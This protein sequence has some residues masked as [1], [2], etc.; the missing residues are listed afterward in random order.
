VGVREQAQREGDEVNPLVG[1]R[2][3]CLR[4]ATAEIT[5]AGEPI[6]PDTK[7]V[8]DVAKVYEKHVRRGIRIA[9]LGGGCGCHGKT[10]DSADAQRKR[11]MLLHENVRALLGEHMEQMTLAQLVTDYDLVFPQSAADRIDAKLKRYGLKRN[12][13][14][15]DV[16]KWIQ[17]G[18]LP[19]AKGKAY[20]P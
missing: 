14:G 6:T 7:T 2:L 16:G 18:L 1:I 3:E 19:G 13:S 17:T 5:Y 11:Q 12:V 4:L 20:M 10:A 9:D 15:D 8:I